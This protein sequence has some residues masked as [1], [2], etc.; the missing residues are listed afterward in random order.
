[1]FHNLP[2]ED[3]DDIY[4]SLQFLKKF[5]KYKIVR[6]FWEIST[7]LE[8]LEGTPLYDEANKKLIFKSVFKPRGILEVKAG[9]IHRKNYQIKKDIFNKELENEE[10]YYKKQGILNV[11]DEAIMFDVI[12]EELSKKYKL[13]AKVR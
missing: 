2:E 10:I 9:Y 7:P 11:N 12:I 6:A 4:T 5:V 3:Y 8:L 13:Y 1:M